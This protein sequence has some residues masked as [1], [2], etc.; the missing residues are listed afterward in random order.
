M[1]VGYCCG[2]VLV[3]V[4]ALCHLVERLFLFFV[5]RRVACRYVGGVFLSGVVY[6]D[7]DDWS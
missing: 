5:M 2:V 3:F 1:R 7:S 4:V 6:L